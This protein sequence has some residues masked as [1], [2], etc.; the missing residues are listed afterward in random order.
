MGFQPVGALFLSVQYNHSMSGNRNLGTAKVAKNDEFY[1]TLAD[2]ESEMKYYK[3][4]FKGKVVLCNCDDPFE[5]AF[6]KYFVLNFNRLQLKKLICTC[7]AGSQVAFEQLSL[8]DTPYVVEAQKKTPYKAVVTTVHDADNDGYINMTDIK[9]LFVSGENKLSKLKGNGDFRSKECLKLLDESDIVCTNPPFSLFRE[10]LGTLMNHHKK[11]IIMGNSNA[12][13]YKEVFPLM[14]NNEV[15][16]GNHNGHTWF[17]MPDN[18]EIPD[19]YLNE[20][21]KKMRSNG[22]W[23]DEDGHKWRNLGNICWFTNLDIKKRHE[24]LLCYKTYDPQRYPKYANFDGIEVNNVNDIPADYDGLIGLPITFM[25]KYNPRQFKIIGYSRDV[26][27]PIK[28]IAKPGD[29]Y[30][31]GGNAFYIRTDGHTLKRLYGRVVVK[32]IAKSEE[33]IS[34]EN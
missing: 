15:W 33:G 24:E 29:K 31:Q 4:H 8:L 30:E 32:R 20:D 19:N 16:L 27:T 34:D 13:T 9:K 26:A 7:Y 5:S 14:M 11:F 23:I 2:V 10:Y 18:Y 25:N 1:T 22:Y 12:I 28:Q 21:R 6:F 3:K 17:R